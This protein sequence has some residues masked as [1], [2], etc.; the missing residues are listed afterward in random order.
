MTLT[1][2]DSLEIIEKLALSI[3]LDPMDNIV[4]FV[5]KF[6]IDAVINHINLFLGASCECH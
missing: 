1:R 4:E 5:N 6:A 2:Y 3:V